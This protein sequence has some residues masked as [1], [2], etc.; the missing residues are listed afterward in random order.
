M[1]KDLAD[2][3]ETGIQ[4]PVQISLNTTTC[5][6]PGRNGTSITQSVPSRRTVSIE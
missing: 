3:T 4:A 1:L 5:P 2:F 6:S